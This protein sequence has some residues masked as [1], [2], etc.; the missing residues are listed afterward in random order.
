MCLAMNPD[1]LAPGERARLD[2]QPQL[3]GTA[4]SRRAHPSGL[5]GG[6]RRHRRRRPLRHP[7]RPVGALAWNLSASSPA[8]AVPLDR[9]DV[10]TDQIIP[11]DWLKRVERTGFGAGLFGEWRDDRDFVLNQPEYA[12]ADDPDRRPELRHRLLPRARRLGP[13]RLRLRGRR[14]PEVRRHLPQQRDQGRAGPRRGRRRRRAPAPRR[15]DRRSGAGD[16]HRRRAAHD[17]RAAG[18]DR[19]ARSRWTSSP[20]TG[21]S[22]AS[23][24]SDSRCGT[25]SRS[26]RSR[27]AVRRGCRRPPDRS[28]H[29]AETGRHGRLGGGGGARRS[30]S[31]PEALTA[32]AP[33]HTS[34]APGQGRAT[35]APA[36]GPASRADAGGGPV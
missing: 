15:R 33:S 6:R 1:K 14:L 26:A 20:G 34:T 22:R 12:G 30:R 21:C 16:H 10:D 31:A 13:H 27:H 7:R 35:P 29:A 4:G 19:G 32:G 2:V 18:R 17:R 11:S 5:A 36:P 28:G 25:R 24:T 23:T 3:R 8:D 9:S